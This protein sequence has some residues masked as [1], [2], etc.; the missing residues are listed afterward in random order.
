M[1]VSVPMGCT[2]CLGLRLGPVS[3]H[4]ELCDLAARHLLD[5]HL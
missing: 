4:V 1:E 3:L 2:A 5:K